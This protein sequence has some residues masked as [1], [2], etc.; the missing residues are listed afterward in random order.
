VRDQSPGEVNI[1]SNKRTQRTGKAAVAPPNSGPQDIHVPQDTDTGVQVI[2]QPGYSI[3]YFYLR[4]ID[5]QTPNGS[6]QDHISLRHD[7]GQVALA[8]CDGVGQ[9]YHGGVAARELGPRLVNWLWRQ[10]PQLAGD[11][12]ALRRSLQE[13][14]DRLTSPISEA[15]NAYQQEAALPQVHASTAGLLQEALEEVRAS[16]S[17]TTFSSGYL[18]LPDKQFP[19]GLLV[20]A[21]LGDSPIRVWDAG[22]GQRRFPGDEFAEGQHWSSRHGLSG[23]APHVYVGTLDDVGRL[24]VHSDGVRAAR[25]SLDRPVEASELSTYVDRTRAAGPI[26]DVSFVELLLTPQAAQELAQ[27][28]LSQVQISAERIDVRWPAVPAAERYE[29]AVR[30]DKEWVER[31]AT[32]A[33]HWAWKIQD[34]WKTS[35]LQVRSQRGQ[36]VSPWS[37][38]Q[39]DRP[40]A[41]APVV[42]PPGPR[43]PRRGWRRVGV[44]LALVA[45]IAALV[46][47]VAIGRATC[48]ECPELPTLEPGFCLTP[49]PCEPTKVPGAFWTT[50]PAASP[51][52]PASLAVAPR[53]LSWAG[54]SGVQTYTVGDREGVGLCGG[55]LP[56]P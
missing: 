15:L 22:G 32:T 50:P 5:S 47:G 39:L 45:V 54:A 35:A 30:V 46:A 18:A 16:G 34:A 2:A 43:P 24:A 4:S 26:D 29:V 48:P 10:A 56:Q 44:V 12:A 27:P 55:T 40:P 7:P 17:E 53:L 51:A 6:G 20:L 52:G 31:K 25:L 49:V 1:V 11:E 36:D 37:V 21:W 19:K 38:I 14:L 42:S 13:F 3:R 41:P 33:T 28:S 8:V 9:S 23:Y